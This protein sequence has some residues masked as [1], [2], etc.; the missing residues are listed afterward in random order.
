MT[1][2]LSGLH[3]YMKGEYFSYI[4]DCKI[5]QTSDQDCIIVVSKTFNNNW[6]SHSG[7]ISN[8]MHGVR[9]QNPHILNLYFTKNNFYSS[10]QKYGQIVSLKRK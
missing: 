1:I 6:L 9:K 7:F 5:V 4:R 8:I 3:K 10:V 2:T